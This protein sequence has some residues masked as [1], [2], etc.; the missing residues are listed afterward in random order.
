MLTELEISHLLCPVCKRGGIV[1]EQAAA[2]CRDKDCRTSF[3]I[4]N[5]KPALV[6]FG[7]SVVDRDHLLRSQAGDLHRR[8]SGLRRRVMRMLFGT[9]LGAARVARRVAEELTAGSSRP[10]L[11]VIGG[12]TIGSGTESLYRNRALDV[13]A[14]D[15]YASANVQLIADAHSLPFQDGAFDAVWI[16]AVLEHVLEP[17]SVVAEIHR[18]LAPSG[19]V[20]AGTPFMQQVHEGPYDFTRFSESGHRW[21]FRRFERVDS[22][23][24]G[25][26]GT[27]AI[28]SIRYLF[29]GLFR[30]SKAGWLAAA[31][32]FW[33]RFLDTLIPEP[34]CVDAACGVWLL[35][36]KSDVPI[37]PRDAIMAYRGAQA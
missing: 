2:Q 14:L 27:A 18:V 36:R 16:Q 24:T 23:V 20:Y 21:L 19:L 35:G 12:G 13:T 1:L 32:V 6:D 28:W 34:A 5:G 8:P 7:A 30:S 26:P 15:I 4:I 37:C 11:L 25:G 29:A 17:A 33:L 22:G 31:S 10:R 9:D 3:P